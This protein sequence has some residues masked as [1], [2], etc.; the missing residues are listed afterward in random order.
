MIEGVDGGLYQIFQNPAEKKHDCRKR[1]SVRKKEG[2]EIWA[3]GH[4]GKFGSKEVEKHW[5]R[6]K[7]SV[8]KG[9]VRSQRTM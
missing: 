2:D 4:G 7:G 3:T 8:A 5:G 1:I 9:Q 6:L